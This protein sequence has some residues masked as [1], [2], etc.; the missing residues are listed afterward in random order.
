MANI[1]AQDRILSKIDNAVNGHLKMYHLWA[2]EN[3]PPTYIMDSLFLSQSFLFF[4]IEIFKPI[5]FTIYFHEMD[6]F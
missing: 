6:I 3:V 4:G 1:P 2:L 5:A